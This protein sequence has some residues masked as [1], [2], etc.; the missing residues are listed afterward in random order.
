MNGSPYDKA[1]SRQSHS[2]EHV[3]ADPDAPRIVVREIGGGSQPVNQPIH[4]H[5][6]SDGEDD[7]RN[8]IER[9]VVAPEI[10]LPRH[11][12]EEL[13]LNPGGL[14]VGCGSGGVH[15]LPSFFSQELS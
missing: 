8:S 9:R 6:Y 2:A 10:V 3:E 1:T 14:E 4:D 11:A 12:Q 13:F 7:G 15:Y 5:R